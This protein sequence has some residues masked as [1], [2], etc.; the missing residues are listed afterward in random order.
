VEAQAHRREVEARVL[1]H[2]DLRD[3]LVGEVAGDVA[4]HVVAAAVHQPREAEEPEE[5]VEEA[6]AAE[7]LGVAVG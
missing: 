5:L 6:A 4:E 1:A 3:H 2:L 7:Q